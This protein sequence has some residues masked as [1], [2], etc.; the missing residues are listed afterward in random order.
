MKVIVIP[1]SFKGSMTSIEVSEIIA[2]VIKEKTSDEVIA[3]PI[4]DGG[5]GSIDC[6]LKVKNGKKKVVKVQSPDH[7]LIEASYGILEDHTAIIEIA[8]C[9]G[10]TKQIGLHPLD[11]NTYGFGELILD[12]L[13]EGCRN[14]YLC[15]GGS[16]TTDCGLG[17]ASALGVKFYNERLV[18]FIPTGESLSK[19]TKIDKSGIDQRVL[20]STFTILTDVTNP[21]FGEQGAAYIFGPQKGASK[22][23]VLLLDQ[24][25]E[26]IAKVIQK[27]C[28]TCTK[29]KGAGAAGGT[30]LGCVAF[31]G[32]H[33]TSGIEGFLEL[34]HFDDYVREA[35]YIIT[36]EGCLDEQ[37]LMGKVLSGIKHHA[38]QK[39]I[40]SFCGICKLSNEILEE[41]NIEAIEISKGIALEE[42]IF[43]GK[44]YLRNAISK[45]IDKNKNNELC[46]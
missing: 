21:L 46:I 43:N 14:F 42:S 23:D 25:L 37:S 16:A 13:N 29:I 8:E 20:L 28:Y 6:I 36:G 19:V 40:V 5:E 44:K 26:H 18:Q 11:S 4:A 2:S 22:E 41:N 15:L 34:V 10:I 7:R 12:A 24:G 39:K 31:L 1:D 17:M 33:I 30:G 38:H 45:Y 3:L 9:S 27:D 35:D 32:G